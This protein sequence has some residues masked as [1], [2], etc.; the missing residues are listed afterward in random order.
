MIAAMRRLLFLALFLCIP[1]AA[2][3]AAEPLTANAA[4]L[5]RIDLSAFK[6]QTLDDA[7]KLL[8]VPAEAL[9]AGYRQKLF[10]PDAADG[11]LVLLAPSDGGVTKNTHYP[12]TELRQTGQGADW[13]LSDPRRHVMHVQAKVVEVAEKK[14]QVI[15]G[16]IHG[17]EQ[18]SELLKLRWTGYRPSTGFVEAR[19]KTNEPTPREFGVVLAERLS[20]GDLLDFTICMQAGRI[21]VELNGQRATHTYTPEARGSSDRY[22]FKAGNYFQ[23]NDRPP[24]TGQTRMYALS[25][26]VEP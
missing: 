11:A 21:E 26:G 22:Y 5:Q 7:G 3:R 25:V 4:L 16:Q 19:F 6:L 14:P 15:I 24:V 10:Y 2:L 13:P 20:L 23:Y 8:E 18:Y 17:S 12:R 1:G 9:V